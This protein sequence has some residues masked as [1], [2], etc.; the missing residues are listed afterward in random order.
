MPVTLQQLFPI[1]VTICRLIINFHLAETSETFKA[2][3]D[4]VE[5]KDYEDHFQHVVSVA[6]RWD[7]QYLC[8]GFMIQYKGQLFLM[9]V[10]HEFLKNV[11]ISI[12]TDWDLCIKAGK[13]LLLYMQIF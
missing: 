4:R 5:A 2:V 6:V 11:S 7:L 12:P 9:T 13:K 8:T 3:A 1:I 10:A